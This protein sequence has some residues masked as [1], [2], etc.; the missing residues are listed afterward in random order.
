MTLLALADGRQMINMAALEEA[1][2]AVDQGESI[3]RISW[4][5]LIFLPLSFMAV[6]PSRPIPFD[7]Y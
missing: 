4:L 6:S 7:L 1:R 2:A 3:R 5:T